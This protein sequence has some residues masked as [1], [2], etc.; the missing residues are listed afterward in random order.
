MTLERDEKFT[1]TAYEDVVP[2]DP[3]QP[4]KN[5]LRAILLSAIADAR[6]PGLAGRKACE[7]LLSREEDYILSFRAICSHLN[8]DP[9]QILYVTGLLPEPTPYRSGSRRSKS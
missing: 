6:K 2:F 5:L 8:V 7:F 4:E 3:S 9:K 1:A